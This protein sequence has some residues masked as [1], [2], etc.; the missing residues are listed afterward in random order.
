MAPTP[1]KI[2]AGD[3]VSAAQPQPAE[4]L[5]MPMPVGGWPADEF[6]GEAGSFARDPYTGKLS[7]IDEPTD[8]RPGAL[9]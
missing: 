5:P 6:S 3:A 9:D 2:D 1:K 7:R 4:R 8:P